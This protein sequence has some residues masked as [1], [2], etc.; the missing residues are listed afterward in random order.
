MGDGPELWKLCRQETTLVTTEQAVSESLFRGINTAESEINVLIGSKKFS[1]GWSSW[2]VST[3][4]LM[5]VGQSEGAEI[6][7]LFGRGVRLQGYGFGLSAV[8]N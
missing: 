3:M 1:A 6:I 7:Q 4:G 5:R 2:R 8:P